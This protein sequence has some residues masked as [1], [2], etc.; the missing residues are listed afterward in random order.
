[1]NLV[2]KHQSLVNPFENDHPYYL[3]VELAAMNESE[4]ETFLD[5]H[6]EFYEKCEEFI[7]EGIVAQDF[8]QHRAIWE[9]RE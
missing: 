9:T 4:D 1:M 2:I 7:A 6:F 3:L 5:S 8:A